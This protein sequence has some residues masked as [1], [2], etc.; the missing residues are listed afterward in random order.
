M[1][2]D[3]LSPFFVPGEFAGDGDTLDGSPVVG[4]FDGAYVKAGDGLGMASTSPAYTLPASAIEG[5]PD[6]KRLVAN[7]I[8]YE[9]ATHEP[10]GT[11]IVIL[12]LELE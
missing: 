2:A 8:A 10:D 1:I 3:D 5:A 6:G 12:H 9:V 4:I 7:G 11:G